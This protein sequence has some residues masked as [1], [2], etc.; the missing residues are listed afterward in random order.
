M[1]RLCQTASSSSGSV[2]RGVIALPSVVAV[3]M[4]ETVVF[5]GDTFAGLPADPCDKLLQHAT[6]G[7]DVAVADD[8]NRVGVNEVGVPGVVLDSKHG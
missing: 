8:A 5:E 4:L 3:L 1:I 6:A 2:E 7:V